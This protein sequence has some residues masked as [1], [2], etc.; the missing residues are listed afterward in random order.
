MTDFVNSRGDDTCAPNVHDA[1]NKLKTQIQME[2]SLENGVIRVKTEF[3]DSPREVR[4]DFCIRPLFQNGGVPYQRFTRG[5]H[6]DIATGHH[7][8]GARG[9][10]RRC[11]DGCHPM[12]QRAPTGEKPTSA[13]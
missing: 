4:I 11:R 1:K 10:I 7:R 6:Q 2:R 12:R 3:G 13:F 9:R 8:R 5:A